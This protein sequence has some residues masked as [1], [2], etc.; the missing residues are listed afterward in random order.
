M[1]EFQT[2]Q[3][4]EAAVDTQDRPTLF[5]CL[6]ARP[7]A[8]RAAAAKALLDSRANKTRLRGGLARDFGREPEAVIM[9]LFAELSEA[10]GWQPS[11]AW[12]KFLASLKIDEEQW[13][14]GIGYDL[15]ALAA[16]HAE[17]RAVIRQWLRSRLTDGGH[18]IDWRELEA[19]AALEDTELLRTLAQ[20][21]DRDVRLRVQQMLGDSAAVEEELCRVL[22][23]TDDLGEIARAKPLVYQYRSDKVKQALI[24]RLRL[25]DRFFVSVAMTMLEVFAGLDGWSE[26]PFLFRVKEVGADGPLMAELLAKVG[27]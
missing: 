13:R 5:A 24:H 7:A 18:L 14:D 12:P 2:L 3:T 1:I 22:R 26:R 11:P 17:E 20:H 25:N 16:M 8:V 9:P 21:H 15:E 27:E 19:A 6:A 23:E 10:I 4:V